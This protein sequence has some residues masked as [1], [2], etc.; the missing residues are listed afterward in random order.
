MDEA[1]TNIIR[2][3][4]QNVKMAKLPSGRLRRLSVTL[5]IID[6]GKRLI[7]AS[8]ATRI[9]ISMSKSGKSGWGI[10]MMRRLM[11]DIQYNITAEGNELRLTKTRD[12]AVESSISAYYN[13]NVAAA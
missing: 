8:C 4:Y 5:V 3:G 12:A 7:R 2:H 13:L 6:K 11:D 1:R 9:W 10:L